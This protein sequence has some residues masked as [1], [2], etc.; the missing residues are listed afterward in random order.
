MSHFSTIQVAVT[1]QA[2][3][4]TVLQEAGYDFVENALVRGYQGNTTTAAIVIRLSHGYDIGLRQSQDGTTYEA[5][6]DWWGVGV[7]AT[8][9]SQDLN[10]RYAHRAI[11]HHAAQQ[12][13]TIETEEVL[14][15]GTVR[16]VLGRWQS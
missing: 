1:D 5:V 8:E 10:Q 12:G 3:L 13:F 2:I 9:F 6:A 14:A 11:L 15:D 7:S 16:V 4:K